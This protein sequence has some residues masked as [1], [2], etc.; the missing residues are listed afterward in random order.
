MRIN[1]GTKSPKP[2]NK[3]SKKTTTTTV[4]DHLT[5]HDVHILDSSGSMM[6]G[7]YS[8]AIEGIN[9]DII[10]SK[11]ASK[12]NPNLTSTM[13]IVEFDNRIKTHIFMQPIESVQPMK[14]KIMGNTTALFQAIGETI[15]TLIRNKNVEDKVLMKIF[16]DGGENSSTGIYSANIG[17]GCKALSDLIKEAEAKHNFTITFVGTKDD[18]RTMIDKLGVDVSNTLVHENT[19]SSVKMSMDKTVASRSAYLMSAFAGEDVSKGFYS[20]TVN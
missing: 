8:A 19:A 7:K 20:K 14:Y 5:V 3:P 6:G 11:E 2:A 15:Q 4:V 16:T 13:T 12:A 10:A 17:G 18:T 9:A 1:M